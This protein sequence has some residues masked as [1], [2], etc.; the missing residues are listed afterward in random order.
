MAA[1]QDKAENPMELG[2]YKKR[3]LIGAVVLLAVIA[4]IA[5]YLWRTAAIPL[6]QPQEA[7]VIGIVDM[8]QLVKKHPNYQKLQDLQQEC[9][10]LEAS[11]AVQELKMEALA[12]KTDGRLFQEA[13]AQKNRLDAIERHSQL[14]EEL[15]AKAEKKRQELQ[16]QFDKELQEAAKPYL[17]EMLNLRVKIDS[18]DVLGLTDED[19]KK[20]LSRIDELQSLRA[21]AT[22]A[23]EKE[24][25]DRFEDL[26]EQENSASLA[27]LRELEKA[28]Q[29]KM[30]Q[31]ELTKQLEAQ[32]RNE[33]QLKQS[34]SPIQKKISNVKKRTLLETKKVQ[35]Q[36]LQA[37]IRDDIA[38]RVAKMAILH[39]L[40]LVLSNPADDL[41]ST[42][43]QLTVHGQW[44]SELVPVLGINTVDLTEEILQDIQVQ[45][46]D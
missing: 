23:L 18:A 10:F 43:Y 7:A 6:E 5:A 35:I 11:L 3:M 42:G 44:Q 2:N 26:I 8:Q 4:L 16:P 20:M 39:K 30:Q 13:A 33:E 25:E 38:G 12:P 40:L 41:R 36:Q 37:K 32:K 1:E 28:E 17:N 27:E 22:A 34:L 19:V 14:I 29:A 21:E 15:N 31:E 24:Q 45:P 9:M 46:F